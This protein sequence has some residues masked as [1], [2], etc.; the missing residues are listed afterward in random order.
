MTAFDTVGG[1]H[2]YVLLAS[3][4]NTWQGAV[5]TGSGLVFASGPDVQF[6]TPTHIVLTYDGSQ[7]RLYVNGSQASAVAADYQPSTQSRLFI[8]AGRPDLPEPRVPWVGNIQCV[9]LYKGA[10]SSEQVAKHA[11]FGKGQGMS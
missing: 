6:D 10:L 5:G 9:A 3:Q 2:G 4:T 1:L 11:G 7:L 8:G